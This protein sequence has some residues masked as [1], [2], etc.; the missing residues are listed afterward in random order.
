MSAAPG[1]GSTVFPSPAPAPSAPAPVPVPV[2]TPEAPVEEAPPADDLKIAIG[3]PI[4]A[5]MLLVF[6]ILVNS[7]LHNTPVSKTQLTAAHWFEN[8]VIG[9]KG[10]LILALIILAVINGH[11]SYVKEHP[12]QFM[13]DSLAIG[14]FGAISAVWLTMTRGRPDLWANHLVFSLLLFFLYNVCREFAGYFT[15]FGNDKM[16]DQE[17]Q[18]Q[19]ILGMPILIVGGI[20]ALIAFGLAVVAHISPDYSE[21]I[22]KSLGSSSALAIETVV[23]VFII[24]LGELVVARNK[25]EPMATAIGV[26]VATFTLAHLVLQGGGFYE[27]LYSAPPPCIS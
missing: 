9:G 13:Q 7:K 27:H 1:S 6:S 16:T 24:T 3:L 15:V 26:S 20:C 11:S 17:K 14:G 2:P 10:G 23:F 22:L 18:Q 8:L 21:G 25:K 4:S 12:K 5:C 19:G